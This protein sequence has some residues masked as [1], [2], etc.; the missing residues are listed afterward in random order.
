[1][2]DLNEKSIILGP[3][4][5]SNE[6]LLKFYGYFKQA[7]AG[8]CKKAKPSIFYVVERAKWDAWNSVKHLTKADAM[9]AYID[10]IKNVNLKKIF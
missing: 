9:Q 3:F 4:Q 5:P 7:T 8:P 6:I 1:M 2:L 10:E